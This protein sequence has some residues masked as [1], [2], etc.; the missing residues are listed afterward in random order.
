MA[1]VFWV[2]FV[3]D[4]WTKWPP[5]SFAFSVLVSAAW[6]LGGHC[7]TAALFICTGSDAALRRAP[8]GRRSSCCP[9]HFGLLVRSTRPFHTVA[10][11]S[12]ARSSLFFKPE[13]SSRAGHFGPISSSA[14]CFHV[15]PRVFGDGY[16]GLFLVAN[17]GGH[18]E[19]CQDYVVHHDD[20]RASGWTTPSSWLRFCLGCA[21]WRLCC[22]AHCGFGGCAAASW[23]LHRCLLSLECGDR[24]G[25]CSALVLLC[26]RCRW[27][28]CHRRTL[29]RSDWV[30]YW[31]IE[32]NRL[33]VVLLAVTLSSCSAG[34][35]WAYSCLTSTFWAVFLE[36]QVAFVKYTSTVFA[37]DKEKDLCV[38][39]CR[40]WTLNLRHP[41]V[42][43]L[44]LVSRIS[45][46]N[47]II[48]QQPTFCRS[49]WGFFCS[50]CSASTF[51]LGVKKRTWARIEILITAVASPRL[52][53]CHQRDGM[54]FRDTFWKDSG[55]LR[56]GLLHLLE[57]YGRYTPQ[58]NHLKM[59]L[60]FGVVIF[61]PAMLVLWQ[62]NLNK[63]ME[64]TAN[65]DITQEVMICNGQRDKSENLFVA[66]FGSFFIF[67]P[68]WALKKGPLV[69]L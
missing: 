33:P 52:W 57:F 40:T 58:N 59:Y 18:L 21:Q 66:W 43:D 26:L 16:F 61:Q 68:K 55:S 30:L 13:R 45:F 37:L 20:R 34:N 9:P 36:I 10:P 22:G 44:Q 63:L 8:F 1:Q 39:L 15:C 23:L 42:S 11:T 49:F 62:I 60:L 47:S 29:G 32:R 54:Q 64:A 67:F 6:L 27:C 14:R 4:S 35:L 50:P 25:T 5:S 53:A 2:S 48:I 65:K 7:G 19:P 38:D 3:F 56:V 28:L 24:P 69:V 51:G 12:C 31:R 41:K 17:M 46:I